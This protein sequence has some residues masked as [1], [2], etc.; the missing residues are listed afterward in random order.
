MRKLDFSRVEIE[1]DDHFPEFTEENPHIFGRAGLKDNS[2][3]LSACDR[4]N[5]LHPSKWRRFSLESIINHEVLH[6]VLY[7]LGSKFLEGELIT[8]SLDKIWCGYEG[9]KKETRELLKGT[10]R[11]GIGF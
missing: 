11:S 5:L 1:E 3:I 4:K 2:I 9:A 8:T 7:S 6:L 10:S